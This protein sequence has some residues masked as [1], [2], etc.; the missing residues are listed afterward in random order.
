MLLGFKSRFA[1]PIL[2]ETK[3]F[4]MRGPRK[5]Q[6]K[7]GETL[8]MYTG[9][10]TKWCTKITDRYRLKG[11]QKAKVIIYAAPNH[12]NV[13]ITVDGRRLSTEET[14]LF[15]KRDGFT[16]VRDFAEYWIEDSTGKKFSNK[17]TYNIQATRTIYHW[18][19][20]RF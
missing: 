4:T 9:L 2:M 19:D 14:V 7:I 12:L 17:K 5:V 8:H 11:R 3:R 1:H 16:C 13:G 10:R 18:T 6:P 20:L 15:V